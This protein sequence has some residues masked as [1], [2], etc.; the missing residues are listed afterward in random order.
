MQ[1]RCA[2]G[3]GAGSA[4]I[5]DDIAEVFTRQIGMFGNHGPVDEPDLHFRA[6]AGAFH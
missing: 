5:P 1:A 6:T 2:V 3:L 4:V